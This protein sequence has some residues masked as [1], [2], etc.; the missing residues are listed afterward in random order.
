[1]RR[2]TFQAII[3]VLAIG[4]G[5]WVAQTLAPLAMA[6]LDSSPK[7][8]EFAAPTVVEAASVAAVGQ[9]GDQLIDQVISRSLERRPNIVAKVRQVVRV[10]EE[11]LSGQGTYWQQG[12]GNLRRTRWELETKVGDDTAFV[13]QVFDGE[14]VWTDR[15]LPGTRKV[16]RVDV[17]K[18][19]RDLNPQSEGQ[20]GGETLI[21]KAA[22]GGL[23]QLI[24]NLARCFAFGPPQPMQ[25]GERTMLAV[26]G[27]WRPA[28]LEK[29]WPTLSTKSPS[30][31]PTHLPHHVLVYIDSNELFPY[32]IEYRSSVDAELATDPTG[33]FATREPLALYEFIDVQFFTASMPPSLF[34]YAAP[35]S[36]YQDVSAR[37]IE[38]LRTPPEVVPASAQRDGAWR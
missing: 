2:F 10:D 8:P 22:R 33:F 18:V 4:G 15:K 26:I 38:E 5:Y 14:Y 35:D 30:E 37:V 9:S 23:S 7:P 25:M 32:L 28:P 12:I 36:S 11:R 24:A 16:T 27:T 6:P 19:R 34:Q 3:G 21:D 17:K 29:E 13:T 31:W 1:M 20:G